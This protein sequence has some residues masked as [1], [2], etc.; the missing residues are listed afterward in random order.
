MK[1]VLYSPTKSSP[2]PLIGWLACA[3]WCDTVCCPQTTETHTINCPSRLLSVHVLSMYMVHVEAGCVL[4]LPV[5]GLISCDER[6][7]TGHISIAAEQVARSRRHAWGVTRTQEETDT[8]TSRVI[9]QPLDC[10]MQG[11]CVSKRTAPAAVAS[12]STKAGK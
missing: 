12:Y 9:T 4:S 5:W 6:W 8:V 3:N 7:F 2:L 10:V 1:C 11:Y